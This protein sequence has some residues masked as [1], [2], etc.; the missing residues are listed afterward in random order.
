MSAFMTLL[1]WDVRLQNR[2]GFY[3]ASVFV[4]VVVGSL[5]LAIPVAA[6]TPAGI[7][8]PALVLIN[9]VITTFFFV[10]GLILIERDEGSLLA[11][12]VSPL[13]PAAYLGARAATLT[14]LAVLETG[15]F[16]LLAFEA[17]ASWLA[18]HLRHAHGR[19]H[20]HQHW[21][22]HGHA[23][24]LDQRVPATRHAR[25]DGAAGAAAAAPRPGNAVPPVLAPARALTRPPAR[26][27]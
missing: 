24:R 1:Q 5:L 23:L 19:C 9:L 17:P 6:R 10:S 12:A 13:S 20:L 11:L 26:E 14:T 8:V 18:L 15:A 16:V 22:G 3:G 2:N 7:W 4:V 27:L 21:C 25:R